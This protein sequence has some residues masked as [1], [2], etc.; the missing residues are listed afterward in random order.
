MIDAWFMPDW[1]RAIIGVLSAGSVK[2]PLAAA[3]AIS[4]ILMA[5]ILMVIEVRKKNPRIYKS[6]VVRGI[7]VDL[8]VS[9]RVGWVAGGLAYLIVPGWHAVGIAG[10][11]A[12]VAA[13]TAVEFTVR[14]RD[15]L[16]DGRAARRVSPEP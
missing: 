1:Y 12:I 8:V 5:G 9:T 15:I 13:C 14:I 11:F 16:R 3:S 7:Y 10:V 2:G 4:I 6:F